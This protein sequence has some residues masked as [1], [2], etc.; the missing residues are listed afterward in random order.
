MENLLVPLLVTHFSDKFIIN[1]RPIIQRICFSKA[2]TSVSMADQIRHAHRCT[3]IRAQT[4]VCSNKAKII[5]QKLKGTWVENYLELGWHQTLVS[6]PLQ[7][8]SGLCKGSI[9]SS[10]KV[11]LTFSRAPISS[12]VTPMSVGGITSARSLF[13]NSFSVTTSCVCQKNKI[14][15]KCHILKQVLYG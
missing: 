7:K 2:S 11:S 15:V 6:C 9:T 12:N 1:S 14:C 5:K 8:S 13:S 4:F 10:F 3:E